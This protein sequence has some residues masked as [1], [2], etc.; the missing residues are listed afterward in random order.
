MLLLISSIFCGIKQN[1]MSIIPFYC[2]SGCFPWKLCDKGALWFNWALAKLILIKLIIDMQIFLLHSDWSI[3]RS[4]VGNFQARFKFAFLFIFC[5]F[6]QKNHKRQFDSFRGAIYDPLCF[7]TWE[8][9]E[10]M[11]QY[12]HCEGE[13]KCSSFKMNS[14][15]ECWWNQMAVLC[16]SLF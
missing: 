4:S 5:F 1:G 15:F 9:I 6:E 2:M 10:Y 13:N 14:W 8:W 12:T 7:F 3:M 11:L 16:P